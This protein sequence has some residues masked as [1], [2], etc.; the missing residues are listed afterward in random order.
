MFN[1]LSGMSAISS[2]LHGIILFHKPEKIKC[3]ISDELYTDT[4]KLFEYLNEVYERL[5]IIK[6]DI[7]DTE[8]ILSLDVSSGIVIFF[9]ESCSNPNGKMIDRSIIKKIKA[10]NKNLYV[11]IDN[12]WL[13]DFIFNPFSC[14]AD[15]VVYSLTKYYSGGTAICGA[16]LG[17]RT[18]I[19]LKAM[20]YVKKNGCHVSPHNAELVLKGIEN[21]ENRIKKSSELTMKL[22]KDLKDYDLKHP[23][24][25]NNSKY[26]KN[27]F[28]S[29]FT[30]TLKGISKNKT[31]KLMK[32]FKYIEIKTSFGSKHTRICP[33]ITSKD[34]NTLIRISSGYDDD[35][36][37]E[38]ILSDLKE[39]LNK[40]KI[41]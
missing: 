29:S 31:L 40:C 24:L 36:N 39:L 23:S 4:P 16:L 8:K 34:V 27:V 5:E 21:M 14:G 22:I 20:E 41:N 9:M 38:N 17:M 18:E 6:I 12:T 13:T 26:F 30:I 19:M 35:N 7:E 15:Y 11:I 1:N 37:Y 10:K 28:P 33:F 25:T 2:I 3:I 32:N